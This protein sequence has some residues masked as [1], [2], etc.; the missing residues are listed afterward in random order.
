ME[1]LA[2]ERGAPDN[3]RSDNGPELTAAV[4]CEW[5][6]Q[7]ST[8]SAYIEPGSPW[9]NPF[10]E[11]FNSRLRDELLNV[12]VFTCLAEA[13][14]LATDWC[15]DYNANHPHSALG[16]MSPERFAASRRSP[17]GQATRRGDNE[18]N[19]QQTNPGR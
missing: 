19:S 11:S 10:V 8:A 18:Q 17:N 15:E 1:R 5:C 12:E 9:Q 14:V 4:L 3:I 6:Q 16:M 7:R 2:A 13:K